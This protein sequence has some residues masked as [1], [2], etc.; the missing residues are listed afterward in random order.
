VDRRGGLP[1]PALEAGDSHDHPSHLSLS[2]PWGFRF[3]VPEV[4]QYLR[5]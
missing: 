4:L 1:H 5:L 3:S 2:R